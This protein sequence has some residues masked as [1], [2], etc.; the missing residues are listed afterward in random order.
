MPQP[1][2][3]QVCWTPLLSEPRYPESAE[4]MMPS[5]LFRQFSQLWMQVPSQDIR[6][7]ER[8]SVPCLENKSRRPVPDKLSEQL[9]H[10]RVKV[11]IPV[12]V[13]GL[14]IGFHL[15][16]TNLLPDEERRAVIGE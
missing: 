6:V 3:P 7:R 14:E 16:V 10:R 1:K 12:C 11:Y 2:V 8:L 5:L 9:G 4:S 15:A 13:I